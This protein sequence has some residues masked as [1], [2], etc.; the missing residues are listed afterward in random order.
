MTSFPEDPVLLVVLVLLEGHKD[1]ETQRSQP[2]GIHHLKS[3]W[4]VVT[5][6][7]SL[8]NEQNC[9]KTTR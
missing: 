8:G 2:S 5:V 1:K 9:W 3:H 4:L 7:F 6:G